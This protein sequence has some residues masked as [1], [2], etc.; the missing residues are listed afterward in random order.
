MSLSDV[1]LYRVD[2]GIHNSHQHLT[3]R[4]LW[5]FN[6]RVDLE[7]LWASKPIFIRNVIYL[8]WFAIEKYYF[9]TLTAFISITELVGLKHQTSDPS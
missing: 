8:H 5:D 9:E 3:I 2:P 7:N 1:C 6:V 4:Y